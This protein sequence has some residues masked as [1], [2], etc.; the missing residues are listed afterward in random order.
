MCIQLL[1]D[2]GDSDG[3]SFFEKGSQVCSH[4]AWGQL[5]YGMEVEV[6][7][8]PETPGQHLPHHILSVTTS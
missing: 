8:Q 1:E 4:K 3:G 6:T 2:S 7:G 5:G